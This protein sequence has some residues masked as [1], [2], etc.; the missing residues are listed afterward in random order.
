[1]NVSV[2]PDGTR[3][4]GDCDPKAARNVYIFGDSFA[5]GSGVNDEQ[6]FAF[7]LQVARRDLCVKAHPVGGYGTTQSFMQFNNLRN[8]IKSDDMVVL[9]YADFLDVRNVVAPSRLREVDTWHKHRIGHRPDPWKL[10][11]ASLDERGEIQIT[12][13]QQRCDENDGY[14]DQSDPPKMDMSRITAELMN[15]IAQTSPAPVYL[16]HY[17]GSK[18]N[19]VLGLLTSLVRRVSALDTDF[20]YLMHDDIEGFDPHPGPYWHYAISRKLIAQLE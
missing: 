9:G 20:D 1:V 16:L 7:L 14:C 18:D 11:K 4:T 19:P 13:V 17:S 3:W 2:N 12:Y 15:K 6:T 5:A 10:P 8:V